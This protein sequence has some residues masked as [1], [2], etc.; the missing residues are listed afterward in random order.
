[1]EFNPDNNIVKLC[2]QG[3]MMQQ[4][5]KSQEADS[6][7]YQAWNEASNDFEKFI[8]SYY[9]AGI[10]KN[11]LDKIRWIET[12]LQLALQVNDDTVKAALPLLYSNLA[13]CYSKSGDLDNAKRNS[14]LAASSIVNPS[15]KGPF[16]HGT[17]A[18][19][20]I[21]DLLIPGKY[22]IIKTILS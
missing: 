10:Q 21:G 12:T 6:L 2:L 18:D 20:Q 8:A 4:S 19:L 9:V 1:M 22:P 13:E 17:K 3:M 11:T 15:D 16:Y 7:F 14:E 5:G